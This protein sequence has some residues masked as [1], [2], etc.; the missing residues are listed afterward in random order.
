MAMRPVEKRTLEESVQWG[1]VPESGAGSVKF[2]RMGPFPSLGSV[3]AS[4]G[5]GLWRGL[6]LPTRGHRAP[7]RLSCGLCGTCCGEKSPGREAAGLPESKPRC[8]TSSGFIGMTRL[9]GLPK[10]TALCRDQDRRFLGRSAL[11]LSMA[12]CR[13]RWRASSLPSSHLCTQRKVRDLLAQA[14]TLP[15]VLACS[16]RPSGDQQG[17]PAWFCTD[18]GLQGKG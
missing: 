13:G 15:S 10:T 3:S 5:G 18:G 12:R 9:R 1:R 14:L 4:R 7:R 17:G 8:E 6:R 16:L 2:A 11:L